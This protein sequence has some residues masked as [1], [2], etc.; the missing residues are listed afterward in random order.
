MGDFVQQF[1]L[2]NFDKEHKVITK[3][4]RLIELFS[5]IGAQAKALEKLGANF[6]HW[7]TCEWAVNSIKSY[8]AIHIKDFND[9]SKD[10]TKEQLIDYLD[11]NISTNNNEPCN[12]KRQNEK[13]LRDVYNNCIATHNLMNIMKVKGKDLEI[14]DV[15][16]YEY[17]MTYSFPCQD[18][19]LAGLRQGMG[20]SQADGGTRSGLLWEVERILDELEHKPQILLMENV[21]EVIGAGNV[22]HFNKW[23]AKLESLGYENYFQIL[24]AKDFNIPQNRR[25]CF[26]VSLLGEYAYD[27][28]LKLKAKYCLKDFLEKDVPEKYFLNTKDIERI[29]KNI[30]EDD[31]APCITANAMQSV[32]HQNCV[33][34]KENNN[35]GYKE[36]HDGDGVNIASRMEHQRGNVQKGSIQTLKAQMEIGVVVE[37]KEDE[38]VFSELEKRL[39]TKD[40]NINRYIGSDKVDQFKDGQMATT[41]YPNGWG[42]G[43][44]THDES[45]AL[46]TIDRPSVKMNLRIRKL[47]PCE[48]MKLMGF[49]RCDYQAMREVGMSDSAIYHCSGDSIVTTCLMA[50]LGQMLPISEKELKQKI[51]DYVKSIV[52]N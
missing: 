48:T 51:E 1:N 40:G 35:Q 39:F 17:I 11:G 37:D 18:L 49:E 25:R 7:K 43:P 9:Y 42:H 8:N 23:L 38:N 4:I 21:P 29:E 45:I 32:N 52:E 36:A 10:L 3:P 22:D 47:V 27:F 2:F 19:S 16:K 31:N 14:V 26:M 13:W 5:G 12:V 30:V 24:N 28:P 44:R 6:E 33:L 15:D 50:L 41:T 46:N 34:I 20:T